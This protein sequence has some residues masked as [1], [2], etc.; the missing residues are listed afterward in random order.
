M[1]TYLSQ[2]DGCTN[3]YLTADSEWALIQFQALSL[4]LVN[5]PTSAGSFSEMYAWQ[6]Q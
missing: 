3:L 4:Q 1:H 5:Y 2:G 6:S